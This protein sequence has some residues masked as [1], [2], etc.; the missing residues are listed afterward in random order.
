MTLS[1]KPNLKIVPNQ[2]DLTPKQRKFV[3][4]IIKGKHTYKDAYCEVYDVKMKKD[5]TPPKWTETES[6]KLLANPKIALS[7]QRA[8]QKVE[9]SSVASSVRTREYVLE[10]LMNE[11]KEA[12]S[13]ASRVRALELLGKTIGLFTDTVEVKETRDSEEIASDIEEKIIA[14][15]EET[16]ETE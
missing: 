9:Q 11:S 10:R 16:T 15:L 13:D 1:K 6:S 8:I 12:D 5:G 4:L 7:I 2:T 14:L 3:D